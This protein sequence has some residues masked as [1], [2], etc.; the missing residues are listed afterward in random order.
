MQAKGS[1]LG[2]GK[3]KKGLDELLVAHEGSI[4][5]SHKILT[6]PGT[7]FRQRG[8][9]HRTPSTKMLRGYRSA[10]DFVKALTRNLAFCS[11]NIIIQYK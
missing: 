9:Y 3:E 6:L 2:S 8:S 5:T 1:E 11:T 10:N 7:F 4:Y